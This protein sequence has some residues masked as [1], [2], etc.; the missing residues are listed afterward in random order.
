M[1]RKVNVMGGEDFKETGMFFVCSSDEIE[2][3][4]GP[5]I[6]KWF[7]DAKKF[8]L[9][10]KNEFEITAISP[11]MPQFTNKAVFLIKV[12]TDYIPT[13]IYPTTAI[14]H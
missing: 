11:M 8:I 12:D 1:D 4:N 13:D 10:N 7:G 5:D 2:S 6:K 9:E 3:Q 14:I